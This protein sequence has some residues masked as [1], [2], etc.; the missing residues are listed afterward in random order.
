MTKICSKCK[1]EKDLEDFYKDSSKS[2][3][4]YMCKSCDKDRIL[5]IQRD[6]KQL[7]VD[8]KGGACENCGYRRCLAAL[9]FHHRAKDE[10]EFKISQ[11]RKK[12]LQKIFLELDKCD[13]LCSN[14]HREKHYNL[15]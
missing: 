6:L 9:D 8:Y 11:V 12:N 13:L 14:C 3:R 2:N 5:K 10:K 1:L 7:L 15:S 4:R